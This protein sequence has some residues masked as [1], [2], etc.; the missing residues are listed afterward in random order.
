MLAE[1]HVIIRETTNRFTSSRALYRV[2][3]QELTLTERPS[4]EAGTRQ[5]GGTVIQV[6]T[7]SNRLSVN[8]EAW[9]RLPAGDLG[10]TRTLLSLKDQPIEERPVPTNQFAEIT[11]QR[12][13][14]SSSNV[15]FLGDVRINHP[16][17][18]WQC[19]KVSI[20]LSGKGG[21]A[22][23]ILAEPKVTFQALNERGQKI[24]GA[25]DQAVYTRSIADGLTNEIV[26][27][28]GRPATLQATNGL[29]IKNN[30]LVLDVATG[31]F[32]VP[33]GRYRILGPTNRIDT[34]VF[35]LPDIKSFQQERRR[36]K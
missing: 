29:T 2:A 28:T 10:G 27:L 32:V 1:G 31:K 4:W 26:E 23:R 36:S 16:Q 25:G 35:K 33:P 34:N 20:A 7:A 18:N 14:L 8:G 17:M 9:M 11:S 30:V 6:N 12:Y 24:S 3:D 22:E 19:D 13:D 21:T 15:F 5:G